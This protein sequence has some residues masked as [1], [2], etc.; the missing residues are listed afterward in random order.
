MT[1]Q[2]PTPNLWIPPAGV[3]LLRFR[4]TTRTGTAPNG[5]RAKVVID[6]SGTVFHFERNEGI[7]AVVRP[8]TVR[9]RLRGPLNGTS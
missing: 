5:E 2:Q 4:A 8:K 3:G 7:D 1:D 9:L 6:D